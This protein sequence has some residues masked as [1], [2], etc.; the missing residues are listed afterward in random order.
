MDNATSKEKL[1]IASS[2]AAFSGDYESAIAD[3][4]KIIKRDPDDKEALFGLAKYS[5][6]IGKFEKSV[7]YLNRVIEIDPEYKMAYNQL[8]YSYQ[9]LNDLDNA[10]K[11]TEKYIEMAPDEANPLDTKGSIYALFGKFDKAIEAYEDALRINPDFTFSIQ[12]MAHMYLLKGNLE[13]ADSLYDKATTLGD[14]RI[15]IWSHVS[16][17]QVLIRAG[18]L[19]SSLSMINTIK[20]IYADDLRTGDLILIEQLSA[21]VLWQKKDYEKADNAFNRCFTLAFELTPGNK[22]WL[23]DLY[24]HFLTESDQIDRAQEILRQMDLNKHIHD[25]IR[26]KYNYSK[27]A[28]AFIEGDYNSAVKYLSEIDK[29]ETRIFSSI[30]LS[31]S[32]LKTEQPDKAIQLL[33]KIHST[34]FPARIMFSIQD[35]N[36][37]YYLGI[38]YEQKGNIPEAI[39]YYEAY[40]KVRENSDTGIIEVNDAQNRLKKLKAGNHNNQTNQ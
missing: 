7:E 21:L 39:R 18:K 25:N 35:V 14:I 16:R 3:L 5:Y 26:N 31:R 30:L 38:A 40:T 20:N 28:I 24:I 22:Y 32:Y 6:D 33:K 9:G 12:Q 2:K 27:G 11:A 36:I 19:D 8:A 23:R 34:Y 17:A 29:L 1:L 37:D 13:K 10:M 15:R 4:K